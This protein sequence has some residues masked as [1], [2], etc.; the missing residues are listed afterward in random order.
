MH[1]KPELL[2]AALTKIIMAGTTSVEKN[3]GLKY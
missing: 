3:I 2:V 1:K